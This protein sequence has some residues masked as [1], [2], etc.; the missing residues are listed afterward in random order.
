MSSPS[1]ARGGRRRSAAARADR[2]ALYE[3]AVQCAEA[4]IDF[5]DDVYK[6]LRRRAAR[7]LREDFCGTATV[8]CEWVRR[9]RDNRAIGIDLDA[10]VQEWGRQHNVAPLGRAGA[11]VR[12]VT[13]D[14]MRAR[15]EP[16]DVV[17]AMNFSYWV[18]KQRALLRRYLRHVRTGL[19]DGGL[20]ILD[21]YGGSE[22]LRV[23]RERTRHRGFTYV[24]D[25]A[26]YDPVTGDLRCHIHFSF[27]DGSRLP[28][29]FTYD[30]RLWSLPEIH[31]LLDEAGFARSTVY[32]QGTDEKTGEPN[33]VFTP[34]EHGE[35][36]PAWIAY[37]VAER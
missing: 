37:I 36:D 6:R 29:A 30:W 23:L 24:W 27:P 12:L 3:K 16:V 15:C 31:E 14:V 33:G 28:R 34:V 20:L 22:A 7:S 35:P 19:A 25:Q 26:H 17:L 8:C 4:E 11:R 9:R 18:F 21:A 5:V 32:W 10:A 1:S 13:A 2:H